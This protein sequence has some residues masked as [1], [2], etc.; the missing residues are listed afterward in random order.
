VSGPAPA[1]RK[2]SPGAQQPRPAT[3]QLRPA[4]G[5]P[6]PFAAVRRALGPVLSPDAVRW[7]ATELAAVALHPARVHVAFPAG[8]RRCGHAGV[9]LGAGW[10]AAVAARVLLAG[11]LPLRGPGLIAELTALY[12][13][14]DT[15]ERCAVLAAL[16]PADQR[17]NVGGAGLPLVEDALRTHDA[18]LLTAALGS[19]GA[20]H[21]GSAA[22]RQA[23]LKCVF[24]GIPIAAIGGLPERADA[25]LSRMLA[26]Y[27]AER[28]I[29]GRTVPPDLAALT[30]PPPSHLPERE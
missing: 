2:P 16:G 6:D 22:Y 24:T 8:A 19:Y 29:A 28:R 5:Q 25:E 9:P 3:Q 4:A 30:G 11:A 18:R 10:T 15:G 17:D 20:R 21:L 7:L 14:G 12:Q 27:A 13:R 26:G 23:V 1:A